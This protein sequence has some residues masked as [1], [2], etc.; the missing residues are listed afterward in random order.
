MSGQISSELTAQVFA[1]VN[2][3]DIKSLR[4]GLEAQ[5]FPINMLDPMTTDSPLILAC[6]RGFAD[7]VKLCLEHGGKVLL[8]NFIKI[9]PHLILSLMFH[10]FRMIHTLNLDRQLYMQQSPKINL[11]VQKLFY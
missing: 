5:T 7:I 10:D 6:R 1:W 2:T 11:N 4:N 8:F 3:N 9:I